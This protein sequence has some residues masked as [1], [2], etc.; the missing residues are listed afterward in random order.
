MQ[1]PDGGLSTR[2]IVEHSDMV[3]I[4]PVDSYGNAILVRQYRKAVEEILLEVPAGGIDVG[5][6]PEAAARRELLE[7]TGF[8][9]DIIKPLA[10]FY[11]S[12]GFCTERG[13]AFLATELTP[14]EAQPEFAESIQ[15]I[16]V[17]LN[18]VPNI[19]RRGELQDAKS[20]VALL[21]TLGRLGASASM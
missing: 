14:G 19:I 13:H 4:V 15:V 10:N 20:I 6:T 3:A 21:L 11:S 8:T 9:A 1:L 7:E 17:P 16:P 5:E 18:D 12:P 2:E